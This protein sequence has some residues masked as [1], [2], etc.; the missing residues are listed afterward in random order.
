[1]CKIREIHV[2][3]IENAM[4]V[5]GLHCKHQHLQIFGPK[6]RFISTQLELWVTVE[7]ENVYLTN[8]TVK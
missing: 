2:N 7:E 3:A 5:R 8:N 6:L 4:T 1:M